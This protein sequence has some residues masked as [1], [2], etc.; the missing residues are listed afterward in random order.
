M[1]SNKLTG[2]TWHGHTVST[3]NGVDDTVCEDISG[4]ESRKEDDRRVSHLE[5]CVDW[6]T[7]KGQLKDWYKLEE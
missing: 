4:S 2:E 1:R 3:D 6:K 7:G 5:G